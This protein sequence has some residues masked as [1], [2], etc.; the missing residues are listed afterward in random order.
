M[1]RTLWLIDTVVVIG[2]VGV[3]NSGWRGEDSC[4]LRKEGVGGN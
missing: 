1:S 3:A 2:I 4:E